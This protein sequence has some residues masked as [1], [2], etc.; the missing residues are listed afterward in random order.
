M[1]GW[2]SFIL[3]VQ[4]WGRM[5][6]VGTRRTDSRLSQSKGAITASVC[7]FP[8]HMSKFSREL[9]L[10]AMGGSVVAAFPYCR[11]GESPPGQIIVGLGCRSRRQQAV[12]A[13]NFRRNAPPLSNALSFH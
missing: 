4:A 6:F 13:P 8:L 3:A 7:G 9:F 2:I 11:S 5:H 12:R 10:G 1:V